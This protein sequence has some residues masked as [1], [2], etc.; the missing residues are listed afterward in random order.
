MS[1]YRGN[2]SDGLK[3][4]NIG[5]NSRR[6][7]GRA[8]RDR[9]AS[10]QRARTDDDADSRAKRGRSG[11]T[12]TPNANIPNANTPNANIAAALS[13]LR[14]FVAVLLLGGLGW[15]TLNEVIAYL[16]VNSLELPNVEGMPIDQAAVMLSALNLEVATY[17]DD[18]ENIPFD[19]V[20]SQ[21]PE[22]GQRVRIGRTITLGVN[23]PADDVPLPNVTGMTLEQASERLQS[24][25]FEVG[26][27]TY[28]FSDQPESTIIA[29]EPAASLPTRTGSNVNVI[30]SRGAQV[31]Q[32][33]LPD[34]RGLSVNQARAR[35]TELGMSN[36]SLV[37]GGLSDTANAILTQ[38]PQ[39]GQTVLASV[40]VTLYHSVANDNVVRVPDLRGLSLRE[41]QRRIIGAGLEVGWVDY[42][43]LPEQ[44][45][46]V[47]EWQPRGYTLPGTTLVVRVNGTATGDNTLAPETP[48]EEPPLWLQPGFDAFFAQPDGNPSTT[49]DNTTTG[50]GGNGD[51]GGDSG[52]NNGVITNLA[53]PAQ[54]PTNT[55]TEANTAA[56]A[57]NNLDPSA[58]NVT[59]RFNPNNYGFLQSQENLF[60]L[61]V[62][63]DRGEREIIN[64]LLREG[65][66]IDTVITIYGRAEL[67]TYINNNLFQ[68]WNP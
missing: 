16:N 12:H 46:G 39:A 55:N 34:L 10:Y 27:V 26:K 51:G 15:Y 4:Q 19:H 21:T 1:D 67:R 48:N 22:A 7:I 8:G 3:P 59:I 23:T 49:P 44:P 25:G 9:V 6:D 63:D 45:A 35:L 68:A 33:T 20:T 66:T 52:G 47:Y 41:A 17:N 18:I 50:T 64:R 28:D 36:V 40:P 58:R 13:V 65:D 53:N 38:R 56:N 57:I 29:Q 60:Q 37:A 32:V 24:L 43:D 31:P 30:L 2:S 42:L 14:F 61:I 11:D 62:S 54:T 5:R